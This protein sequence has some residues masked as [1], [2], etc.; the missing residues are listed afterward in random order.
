MD[1]AFF[2]LFLIGVSFA[3]PSCPT[4]PYHD[5]VSASS[6]SAPTAPPDTLLHYCD[7]NLSEICLLSNAFNTTQD[8]KLFIAESIA[9]DSFNQVWQW[10][11]NL[12]FGKYPPNSSRSSTNIKDAWVSIAYLN[13]SVY[14][15]GTYL[16]NAST[17]PLITQN[18]TFV[19]D[20]HQLSGDCRDNF[21]ICGYDYSISILN[22]S[23]NISVKMNVKSEYLVDRYHWVTHCD[24]SGCWVTCDYYRTDSFKD[25]LTASD[26][27]NTRLTTFNP[28][29]NYSMLAYYNGLSELEINAN[30]SNVLFQIGNSSFYKSNYLY[31]I[32]NELGCYN[33]LI[34]EV[35]P[36]NKTSVYGLSI[37]NQNN[38]SFRILA[39]YFDNCSLKI[40]DYFSSRTISG[41]NNSN[42]TNDAT[43]LEIH[44]VRPPFFDSLFSAVLLGIVAY[45]VYLIVKKVMSLA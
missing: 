24:M 42:I 2:L 7:W 23:S 4:Y 27:K 5:Y 40:S 13:P 29:S 26:T 22:T 30:D 35:I 34:T 32:R 19:V 21:R 15:N 41:C 17:Q 18:F 16:I 20:T 45:A 14:D 39:P 25:H 36:A 43:T 11:S 3:V 38:S 37:L 28:T 1:N 12:S 8:K 33:I 9:N 6:Y 10:N 44:P 31:R